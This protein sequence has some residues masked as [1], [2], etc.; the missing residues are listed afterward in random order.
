MDGLGWWDLG[1]R[2][3]PQNSEGFLAAYRG[4]KGGEDLQVITSEGI[5]G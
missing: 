1:R 3:V 2:N 4:E 5:G